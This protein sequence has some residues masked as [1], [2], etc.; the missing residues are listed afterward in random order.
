M[1]LLDLFKNVLEKSTIGILKHIWY[2][3]S[4]KNDKND[5][6]DTIHLSRY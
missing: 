5:R 1:K 6:H 2:P 3:S 4:L